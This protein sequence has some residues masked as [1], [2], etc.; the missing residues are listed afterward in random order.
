MFL[1]WAQW[2]PIQFQ[3][4][5]EIC[6][7]YKSRIVDI[8]TEVRPGEH[9]QGTARPPRSHLRRGVHAGQAQQERAQGAGRHCKVSVDYPGIYIVHSDHF[10]PAPLFWDSIFW[11]NG[12]KRCIFKAF[13]HLFNVIFLLFSFPFFIFFPNSFFSPADYSTPP[14]YHSILH[15]IYPCDYLYDRAVPDQVKLI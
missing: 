11:V 2:S 15:N 3:L 13:F 8:P 5:L 10:L 6:L 12:P 4:Y 7:T 9:H 1:R 14:P